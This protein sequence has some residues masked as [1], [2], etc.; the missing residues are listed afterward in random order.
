MFRLLLHTC[1]F[2]ASLSS[3]HHWSK[4]RGL[5]RALSFRSPDFV[6]KIR[7]CP[8]CLHPQSCCWQLVLENLL[9]V[10]EEEVLVQWVESL[11]KFQAHM[12]FF[13]VFV[14]I[15]GLVLLGLRQFT[16][17]LHICKSFLSLFFL[18]GDLERSPT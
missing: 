10:L 11:K 14:L 3:A 13:T 5:S 12:G 15:P 18:G 16:R 17:L 2:P 4:R 6:H 9:L 7:R 1:V 8:H